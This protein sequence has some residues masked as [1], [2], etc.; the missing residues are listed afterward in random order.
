MGMGVDG[1]YIKETEKLCEQMR[2]QDYPKH[3]RWNN[4]RKNLT[5]IT[6]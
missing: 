2:I 1:I 6:C 5:V 4:L 3:L